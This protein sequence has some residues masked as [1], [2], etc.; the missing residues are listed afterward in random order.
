MQETKQSTASAASY[1]ERILIVIQEIFQFTQDSFSFSF[2]TVLGLAIIFVC[3]LYNCIKTSHFKPALMQS[4]FCLSH[5]VNLQPQA[6]FSAIVIFCQH[7]TGLQLSPVHSCSSIKSGR[8]ARTSF[9]LQQ[10]GKYILDTLESTRLY[11]GF[12]SGQR[13]LISSINKI[14]IEVASRS[15][16]RLKI[17]DLRK[18]GNIRGISKFLEEKFCAQFYFQK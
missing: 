13:D 18:L 3:L 16:E 5:F 7:L 14:W 10:H 2:I 6:T 17:Q 9:L 12:S 11:I 8:I 4:S 1:Q 15:A